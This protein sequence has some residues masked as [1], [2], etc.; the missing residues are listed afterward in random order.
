MKQILTGSMNSAQDFATCS[1]KLSVSS[2]YWFSFRANSRSPLQ[3]NRNGFLDPT[4]GRFFSS[5]QHDGGIVIG[6]RVLGL[7]SGEQK[8]F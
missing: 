8:R 3:K 6:S 2:R 7:G 4:E 1:V 5:V